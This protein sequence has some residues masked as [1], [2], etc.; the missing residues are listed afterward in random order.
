MAKGNQTNQLAKECIV[1][2]LIQLAEQKPFSSITISELTKRAGVSRMTY[3]RNYTSKEEVFETYMSEIVAEYRKA[4]ENL[5]P[6]KTY[7]KYENVLQCFRYFVKYKD[8]IR[9]IMK[10][11]M[12]RILLDALSSYLIETYYA[13]GQMSVERY[14]MLRAYEGALLNVYIGWL[15]N[16]GKEP[17]EILAEILCRYAGQLSGEENS[18]QETES[19]ER[20]QS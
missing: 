18:I 2:A 17:V 20:R 3:Y 16:G 12:E 8:F 5:K 9:C 6:A 13:D 10:I 19:K 7:G 15:E 11:G 4:I 14:Y 1:T